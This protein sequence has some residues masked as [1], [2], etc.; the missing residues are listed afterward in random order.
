MQ[1]TISTGLNNPSIIPSKVVFMSEPNVTLFLETIS[2]TSLQLVAVLC[3]FRL[4]NRSQRGN[5]LIDSNS[6]CS[7]SIPGLIPAEGKA[8]SSYN[9]QM[10]FLPLLSKVVGKIGTRQGSWRGLVF[11]ES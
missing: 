6:A 8:E 11:P 7:A 4:A 1:P 5:G 9:T 2:F 3:S 10:I